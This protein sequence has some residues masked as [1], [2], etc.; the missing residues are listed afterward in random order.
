MTRRHLAFACKGAQLIGTLDLP[1][2][3]EAGSTGLLVVSGGNEV[4]A[5]AWNGQALLAARIAASGFPVFRYDRR[6]VGDSEGENSGF[7][8]SGPDIAAALAAFRGEVPGLTRVIAFGNCDAAAALMLTGGWG[9]DGLVLAN[10]WTFEDA[11]DGDADNG[12]ASAEQAAPAPDSLRA[13]YRQRLRDPAALL[14]LLRGGVAL[15][16]LLRSLVGAARRAPE[17]SLA[18]ELKAGLAGFAGPVA[19]LLA[20]RDRTA[21]TFLARWDRADPR[22]RHC[23]TASHSFVEPEARDWLAER[24]FEALGR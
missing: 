21:Q 7:R 5:G 15:G 12:H 20:G 3:A 22:L 13:H 19:I 8:R 6:G 17:S 2:R 23:P 9:C 16:P 18:G 24:L 1:K 10:P 14:R 11:G 4:R